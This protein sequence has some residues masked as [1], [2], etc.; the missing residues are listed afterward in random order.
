MINKLRIGAAGAAIAAA[1]GM[2]SAAFA[3]DN[4]TA[5]ATAEVLQALTL[6]EDG[7]V[8]DFG[9]MVV[10]GA[11][12]VTLDSANSLDC[13]DASIVCSGTTSVTGFDISGGNAGLVVDISFTSASVNL[14]RQT[15]AGTL[16]SD[17]IVLDS[18]TT[19]A[20]GDQVTLDGG[21]AGSFT[22]GGTINFDGSEVPGIYDGTYNVS[23]AYN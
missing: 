1:M 7:T 5:D 18:F 9:S 4:A 21:G 11:G 19:S 14:V 6:V 12:T 10:T 16:A 17:V 2:S 15:T 3:Q 13:T 8:L 20:T 23:V 22:V